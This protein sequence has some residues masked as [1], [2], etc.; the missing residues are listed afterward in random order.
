MR[1]A[2]RS[3]TQGPLS[4]NSPGEQSSVTVHAALRSTQWPA[5]VKTVA[6][7]LVVPGLLRLMRGL[8]RRLKFWSLVLHVAD[9]SP[10]VVGSWQSV[11]RAHGGASF[12]SQL[13][14]P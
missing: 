14:W 12:V 11:S 10:P 2:P 13:P 6:P 7:P 3:P 5:P 9:G 1:Q 8:T 4:Q